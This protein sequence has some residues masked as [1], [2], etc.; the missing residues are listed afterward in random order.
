MEI[1]QLYIKLTDHCASLA[2]LS[3]Y[4]LEKGLLK[5]AHVQYGL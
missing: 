4:I 1:I 3:T 5:I 2:S